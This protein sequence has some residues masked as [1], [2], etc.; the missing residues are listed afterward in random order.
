MKWY[1]AFVALVLVF[2]AGMAVDGLQRGAEVRRALAQAEQDEL[3]A[4]SLQAVADSVQKL[5]QKTDTVRA[6]Q[7]AGVRAAEKLVPPACA[8]LVTKVE[9]AARTDS[10]EIEDLKKENAAL[11][12]EVAVTDSANDALRTAAKKAGGGIVLFRAFGLPVKVAPSLA[13]GVMPDAPLK[14][15]LFLSVVSIGL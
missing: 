4:D 1:Y 3:R 10:G 7:W 6:T 8:P 5:V 14:P 13:L 9:L 2:C 15:K 11:R 12:A